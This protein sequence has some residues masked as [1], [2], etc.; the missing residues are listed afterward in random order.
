MAYLDL[1]ALAAAGDLAAVVRGHLVP[2]EV[3]SLPFRRS[4]RQPGD[5]RRFPR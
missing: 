3:T 2:V 4:P 1:D 5:R